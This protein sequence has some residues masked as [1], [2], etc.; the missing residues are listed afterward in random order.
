MPYD[1]AANPSAGSPSPLL[2]A[3]VA[4]IVGIGIWAGLYKLGL[5]TNND[6]PP[7][8]WWSIMLNSPLVGLVVGL[9]VRYAG[10]TQE[11]A[12]SITAA[13][14]TFFACFLGYVVV[15]LF[16]LKWSFNGQPIQPT[17]AD[18]AGRFFNDFMKVL[19]AAVGSW[20]AW[21]LARGTTA[22]D[23]AR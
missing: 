9:A 3:V 10:R 5:M 21:S 1:P 18:A 12:V 20:I 11:R 2:L 22:A 19:L 7:V 16:M 8:P 4:G 23:A 6:L 17:F 13:V 14:A 15:D